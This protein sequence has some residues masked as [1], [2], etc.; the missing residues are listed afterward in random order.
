MLRLPGPSPDS[1]RVPEDR[2]LLSAT[3]AVRLIRDGDTVA[4]A[5]FAGTGFAEGIALALEDLFLAEDQPF[6]ASGSARN[7]TLVHAMSRNE[8]RTRGLNHL[9]HAGLVTR[10]IGGHWSMVPQL[11]ALALANRIEAYSLPPTVII[12]LFRD[13][14]A[15]RPG[16]LT[17]IGLGTFADPRHGG[18]RINTITPEELVRLVTV[19]GGDALFYKAFPIDVAIIRGSAADARGNVAAARETLSPEILPAAMAARAC[20]GIVIAEV[21]RVAADETFAPED[22]RVPAALVD[23]VVLAEKPDPHWQPF[24]PPGEQATGRADRSMG[25]LAPT[26]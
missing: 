9:A 5:G 3:D 24:A 13:I 21:D 18:G 6:A 1:R 8:G 4:V 7:L 26:A 10:V 25:A 20:G 14:A 2:K 17:K 22:V 11:H 23:A 12:R 15:H 19:A 16:H